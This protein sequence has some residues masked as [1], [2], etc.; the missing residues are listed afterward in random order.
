MLLKCFAAEAKELY[1]KTQKCAQQYQHQLRE[2]KS[3][4]GLSATQWPLE[5]CEIDL[6]AIEEF[7]V[8]ES[9][10]SFRKLTDVAEAEMSIAFGQIPKAFEILKPYLAGG[11]D[12]EEK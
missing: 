5:L 12:P 8:S 2:L 3:A 4:R 11:D 10:R 1:E 7:A 6:E 9:K